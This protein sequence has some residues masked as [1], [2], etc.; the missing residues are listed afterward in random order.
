MK[1]ATLLKNLFAYIWSIIVLLLALTG[2]STNIFFSLLAAILAICLAPIVRDKIIS[3]L[4]GSKAIKPGIFVAYILSFALLGAVGS[5]ENEVVKQKTT[6]SEIAATKKSN[7]KDIYK[8]LPTNFDYNLQNNLQNLGLL[9]KCSRSNGN[10]NQSGDVYWVGISK[11]I[12]KKMK[13]RFPYYS[14]GSAENKTHRIILQKYDAFLFYRNELKPNE[15]QKKMQ[16]GANV[17]ITE[18]SY[19]FRSVSSVASPK[20][21]SYDYS[22]KRDTGV[23]SIDDDK[24]ADYRKYGCSI[25]NETQKSDIF[26]KLYSAVHNYTINRYDEVQ[27][28]FDKELTNRK[29]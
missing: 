5:S 4:G 17:S 13:F 19:K 3:R 1:A 2:L 21:S 24:Y 6:D 18:S 10:A 11:D 7:K 14:F 26:T 8:P 9:L 28:E 23:L 20:F 29:F 27:A 22:I 15:F 25:V 16:F 12:D